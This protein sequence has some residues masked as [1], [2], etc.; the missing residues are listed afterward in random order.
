MAAEIS[1]LVAISETNASAAAAPAEINFN[2]RTDES[3][4]AEKKKRGGGKETRRGDDEGFGKYKSLGGG[5]G[6][7][8]KKIEESV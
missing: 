5:G 7:G 3:E 1:F 6:G 2:K 4:G 8:S